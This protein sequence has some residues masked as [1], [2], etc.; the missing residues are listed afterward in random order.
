MTIRLLSTTIFFTF[1]R[2]LIV[3][4]Y[5]TQFISTWII[6]P[7]I[8]SGRAYVDTIFFTIAKIWLTWPPVG[9]DK[10]FARCNPN[11]LSRIITI[12]TATKP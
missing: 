9:E 10:L 5:E 4:A 1:E 12:Y 2:L 3:V 11:K 7:S 6:V 8:H